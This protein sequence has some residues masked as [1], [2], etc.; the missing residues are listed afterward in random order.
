MVQIG[1]E[2]VGRRGFLK[3]MLGAGAFVLSLRMMPGGGPAGHMAE[4]MAAGMK[5]PLSPNVWLAIDTDGAVYIIAHRSEMGS[6]SRTAVPRI[7]ADELDADWNRVK[8]VQATGDEK[9]GDQDTDGSHSVRGSFDAMREAGATAR[10]MLVRAAAK[11]WGVPESECSTDLHVVVH[12]SSGKKLGYGE[13]ATAA[14]KLEVPKKE[15]L[16]LKTKAQWR[17]IG[18]GTSSYDLKDMVTGKAGYG[19]DGR[20]DG[21]LYA[22]VAHPP[23]LGS[24]VK[25]VD[26]KATLAVKGVK[27][28]AVLDSWKPPIMFQAL[29][30]VAVIADNTWSAVEGKKKLKIE[31]SDSEHKSYSSDTY[32][33]EMEETS[34]KPG[35]VVRE[36]GNVDTA[37]AKG[38]KIIEAEYYAPMLA[39]ASME[40]PAA[41]AVYKDGKA[42]VWAATQNPQGAREAVAA[43]LGLKKESVTMNVTLL[44]GGFGRK[45]FPD[46]AVEAAVL[47]KQTGK[48]VKVTW[49]REDDIKFDTFH[50][51]AAM[52]LKAALGAD[53]KPTAWLQRST[54]PPIAS[55]FDANAKTADAGEIGLGWSDLPY[56]IPNHRAENGEATTHVRIGW[57]RS[58]CNV[59][60]AFAEHSFADELAHA[61]GKDS[62]EYMLSLLGP[63]RVIP[64]EELAK[65]YTNYDGDYTQYPIDTA[66]F[67]RVVEIAT[68]KAEWGKK[69]NGNG[70]GMGL[71]MHRS[72][73]TYVATVVQVEI[74]K[75]GKLK[76]GRVDTALDA[77]TIVNP[78]MARQQYEGAA[79]FSTSLALYGEITAKNGAI[80]QSNF[81][82][83]PMTRMN[84]APRE[85]RVH[86]VESDAPPAGIGEP[87]VPPFTPALYNAIFAATGKRYRELPL[88]KSGL[89]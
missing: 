88:S 25:S 66:R 9:Y 63:D 74:G 69:K 21:M 61:A 8:I 64:K 15:E 20:M 87:G 38:G 24:T 31:W 37:F 71:A 43:A 11:Q 56:A 29:G 35:K 85:T 19:I 65:D 45:S 50:S 12:K 27:Q 76:I 14:A 48:P 80:E 72:F 83:Y 75:D 73:L 13:L 84:M 89:V 77:G 53:G 3:G 4:E 30:G 79:T 36:V 18:K 78:E 51:C 16:K 86:L 32:R 41:L 5:G 33:K 6:G 62:R 17:Y 57:L 81:D 42:E 2:S 23:V 1:V 44:G 7:A 40:P 47:S 34:R 82:G 22:N 58:V 54:F 39:H 10:L 46:Y 60:H 67:R 52:Y 28:T 70:F 59:F 68:E 55:T 26:D 49:S